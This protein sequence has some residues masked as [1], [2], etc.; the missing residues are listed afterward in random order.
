MEKAKLL[1]R[2]QELDTL[3]DNQGLDKDGWALRHHLEDQLTAIL[4]V[5]EE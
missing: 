1:Q 4:G 2:I 3:V 5:E